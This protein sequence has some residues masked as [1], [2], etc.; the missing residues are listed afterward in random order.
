MARIVP[1]AKLF[2]EE[3]RKPHGRFTG[4][5]AQRTVYERPEPS[6]VRVSF[7]RFEPRARTYWHRHAGGQVLHVV[8]G[9]AA[10]QEE[11]GAVQHLHAGDSAVV[12]PGV[13]HWHG[14]GNDAPM[15]HMAI[16]IGE[17]EWFGPVE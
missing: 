8:E 1:S 7:V 11:G 4:E 17:L 14:S 12:P 15:T 6:A 5:A 9:E 10:T 2:S 16:S 3:V 13:K